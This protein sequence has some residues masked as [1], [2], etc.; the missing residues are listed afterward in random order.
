MHGWIRIGLVG[1][2]GVAS[3]CAAST[4]SEQSAVTRASRDIIVRTDFESL[5]LG[6]A[7][8]IVRQLRPMWMQQRAVGGAREDPAVYIDNMRRGGLAA[9]AEVPASAVLEIRYLNGTDAT[10]RL[11]TGHRAGAILVTTRR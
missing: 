10:T 8:D 6:T 5:S 2:L 3:A 4:P 1:A 7:Q 9:L 11:G